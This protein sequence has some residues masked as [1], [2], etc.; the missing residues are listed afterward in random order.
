MD[1]AKILTKKYSTRQFSVG[2]TYDSIKALDGGDIPT[3]AELEKLWP[4]V[5]YDTT[6][7]QVK[8]NRQKAY[9]QTADPLFFEYQRGEIP[10]Q[11]WLDAIQAVKDAHPY[12]ESQT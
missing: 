3:L 2:S 8:K 12:P 10:Q 4:Q 6:C 11:E 9:Q 5:Q 1:I 7:A